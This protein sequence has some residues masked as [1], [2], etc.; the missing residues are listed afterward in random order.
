MDVSNTFLKVGTVGIA[1]VHVSIPLR[2]GKDSMENERVAT[3][4][5]MSFC[6]DGRHESAP[7]YKGLG[8]EPSASGWP[9]LM[10]CVA[11]NVLQKMI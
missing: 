2:S 10:L 3:P 6:R 4:V 1:K 5:D 7:R 8:L 11:Y 9:L